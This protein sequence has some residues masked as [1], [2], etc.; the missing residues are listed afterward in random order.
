MENLSPFLLN[1]FSSQLF[2]PTFSTN[3]P[4][5]LINFSRLYHKRQDK[6]IQPMLNCLHTFSFSSV[7]HSLSYLSARVR[8]HFT[9]ETDRFSA[10]ATAKKVSFLKHNLT[11]PWAPL[12]EDLCQLHHLYSHTSFPTHLFLFGLPPVIML[13]VWLQTCESSE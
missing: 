1:L 13:K 5:S 7:L 11:V 10:H 3:C 9:V 6:I 8:T 4:P 2:Y 12:H